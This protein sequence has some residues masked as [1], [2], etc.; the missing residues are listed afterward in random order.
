M[1]RSQTSTTLFSCFLDL[2][3]PQPVK[4]RGPAD[5][6]HPA[7]M[8]PLGSQDHPST[9]TSTSAITQND[10][11]ANHLPK[12]SGPFDAIFDCSDAALKHARVEQ[13]SHRAYRLVSYLSSP[14]DEAEMHCVFRRRCPGH[15]PTWCTVIV[16]E[17][18][19][20]GMRAEIAAEAACPL[21]L[22]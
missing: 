15:T 3:Y 22:M 19:V 6:Y 1:A 20:L 7:R 12:P 14:G 17:I 8:A 18:N 5:K 2:I 9:P 10:H 16:K 11:P 4:N 21:M 13:G